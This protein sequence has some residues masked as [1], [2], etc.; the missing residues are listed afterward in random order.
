MFWT[1]TVELLEHKMEF[2]LIFHLFYKTIQTRICLSIKFPKIVTQDPT[3]I[4]KSTS[5]LVSSF[6]PKVNE[7][8]H[9]RFQFVSAIEFITRSSQI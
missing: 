5:A 2:L 3:V 1:F 6:K 8:G 4:R 7:Q 9:K